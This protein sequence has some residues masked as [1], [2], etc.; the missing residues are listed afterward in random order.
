MRALHFGLFIS[1][2]IAIHSLMMKEAQL[3]L[4]VALFLPV[5]LVK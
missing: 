5:Q 3:L 2:Q 1:G 4:L